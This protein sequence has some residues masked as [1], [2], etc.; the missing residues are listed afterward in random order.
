MLVTL[1]MFL[2]TLLLPP[3]VL[4]L[5]AA[6]GALLAAR[7]RRVWTRR[8]GWLLLGTA[9]ASLWALSLP[10]AALGLA[11][12][13]ERCAV[14]DA[15]RPAGAGAI[16][17]LGGGFHHDAA[18]EFGGAPMA[19]GELL[20]RVAYGAYLARRTGLPVLVSGTPGEA[21]AMRSTLGI[22]FGLETRWTEERS[23][24]TFQN[25]QYSAPLLAAAGVRRILLVTSADH[26][27]RAAQ[28]FRSAG[29]EVV[30][31]P[32]RFADAGSIPWMQWV[33]NPGAL[34]RS[35]SALYELI[36]DATRRTLA[37]LH[38]RRQA[39]ARAG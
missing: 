4:L 6:A 36:G 1:K 29:L 35:T 24:D 14:L 23:R 30:P 37:F 2:H 26:E 9:L 8:A 18:P 31:A 38:L 17:I 15:G 22:L 34:A 32:T 27:W 39:P 16:V 7:A 21:A 10:V 11:R 33:P 5:A 28:E 3:G 19:A 20:E 12:A 13:A 25:A